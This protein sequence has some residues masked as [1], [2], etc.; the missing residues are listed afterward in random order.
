MRFEITFVALSLCLAG[1]T[2]AQTATAG[3]PD[4]LAFAALAW[5]EIGPH[6]GGRSVAV[7][8][9]VARPHEYYMGTTGG[10]VFKSTDGGLSW[11]A[12]TDKYFGG[13]IGGIAVSE[14]NPDVVYVGT[15]EY[16][17]RGNVSHGDGVYKTT[18]GGKTWRY[19]GLVETR[20]ISRVRVHPKNP[21][22]VYVAALGHVWAPNPERGIFRSADG[23]AT[24][25][26][27]LFRNDSTGAIELVMDPAEPST[28]YAGF[29]QAGRKPWQLVSGG[30]G[31]GIFKSTDGGERWTELTRKPGLPKGLIGN[32][33]LAVSP[34]KPSIVWALI[35][36]D[37]GGVFRSGDGGES[38]QR[39]NPERKLRQRAWYYTRIYADPKDTNT[40]Y[41]SN[42]D[43]QRST[44]G[45]HTFR[46]ISTPH[47]DS[48]D[49]WIAPDDRDRMIEGNDGGANVSRN[50]G[51]SWTGQ[52]YATAQ[53]YH[54]STTTHFPYQV[55]GAQQDNSTLC[56]PS[57]FP[58][59]IPIGEWKDAGGCESGYVVSRPDD[60]DIVYA[61]CYGGILTRTDL[62][63]GLSRNIT[64]WP[65]N[66]MGQSA[67]DLKYRF[68]WTFP[69]VV[70]PH[71]PGTLYV[72]GNLVFRSTSD[73]EMGS[74]QPRSHPARSG[75]AGGVGWADHEGPDQRGIL[76]HGLHHRRVT[77]GAGGALGRVGRRAHSRLPR[78]RHDLDQCHPQGSRAIHQGVTDRGLAAPAGDRVRRGQP[79]SARRSTSLP[80]AHRRLW[81]DVA[82]DRRRHRPDAFH[83]RGAGGSGAR[84]PPLRRHGAG[85]LDVV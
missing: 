80:L 82:Q 41:V 43:F 30:A 55:C 56:G 79:V 58:G 23:G 4:S 19:S 21:D 78:R 24:W 37:S 67:G 16:P 13:T 50:R 25:T 6:R 74:D 64:V 49:L 70:S 12:V 68:Q 40:V 7:A 69:I 42:V 73:G 15:G 27:I 63:T 29:W 32:I 31:S 84:R 51:K 28:L 10:G 83:P 1:T 18:D 44:D 34:A 38:W 65:V 46:S 3:A 66:P 60:P 53:W 9:S 81:Q 20:Q 76:R 57:R 62:R 47:S 33:G 2:N 17:I 61:G 77:A 52:Q 26:R 75:H 14:S 48:H 5:R 22:V 54:V 45:G 72:G 35:E 11:A 36:S 8:G 85:R 59:G 39:V 71:D